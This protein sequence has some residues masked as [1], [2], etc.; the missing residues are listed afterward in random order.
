MQMVTV[1][2]RIMPRPSSGI[3]YLP[4]RAMQVLSVT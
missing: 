4:S 3:E 2:L 1:F